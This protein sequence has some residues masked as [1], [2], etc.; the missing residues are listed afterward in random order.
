MIR[1]LPNAKGPDHQQTNFSHQGHGGREQRPQEIDAVVDRQIV[2]VGFLK[3][4]GFAVFLGKGFHHAN[5]WNRVG[6]HIGQLRPN[7]IDFFEAGAQ[8]VPHDVNQ[9]SN[10]GQRQQS[11]QGQPR[12]DAEQNTGGHEDH[13]NIG[14]EV[15]QMQRQEHA[16]AVGL[17]A[18]AGHQVAGAAA[19]KVFQREFEQML[20][21]GGT[22]IG[23][24]ALGSQRQH[25]GFE[26][27]QAP[28]KQ[29]CTQQTTQIPSHQIGV[30]LLPVLKR[31]Q[32]LVHQGH[33]E[34][35]RHQS[36]SGGQ[37]C[38]DKAQQQLALVGLGKAPQPE[39]APSGSWRVVF[40]N[41]TSFTGLIRVGQRCVAS[42]APHLPRSRAVP[43]LQFVETAEQAG[44]LQVVT[45]GE[46]PFGQQLCGVA[47]A[48]LAHTCVVH[49]F[50]LHIGLQRQ[51]V[52]GFGG[53]SGLPQKTLRGQGQQA[54]P[55][56]Q[57]RIEV[58]LQPRQHVLIRRQ[59]RLQVL[60]PKGWQIQQ[61]WRNN[62]GKIHS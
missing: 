52:P 16:Q 43:G 4:L 33:G 39:Q 22:Q 36:G 47:G 24:D 49:Q 51:A 29:S 56:I 10:E 23:A 18:N 58:N 62:R 21:G 12:V 25:I 45:Q 38:E 48:E 15:Q 42:G 2:F 57:C 26:P 30:N 14:G 13:Q 9:P 31:D 3:A 44:G 53:S 60:P 34:V 40:V 46:A 6:Q 55:E 61:H 5:A 27:T 7:T 17:A 37:E 28:G 35:G 19:A 8:A 54:T 59:L 11:G 41:F 20:I 32:H 1:H 50:Q